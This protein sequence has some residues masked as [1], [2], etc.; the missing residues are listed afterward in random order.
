MFAS[1]TNGSGATN[2]TVD[3]QK[4]AIKRGHQKRVN[5]S[6]APKISK[7]SNQIYLKNTTGG[8]INHSFSIYLSIHRILIVFYICNYA[9]Y[10]SKVLS[11]VTV[12]LLPLC[13]HIVFPVI[14][15]GNF[16][17]Q[18]QTKTTKWNNERFYFLLIISPY[19]TNLN[20]AVFQ[21][22][23]SS[24]SEDSYFSHLCSPFPP[25]G[26][27]H[28]VWELHDPDD[29]PSDSFFR[30][31]EKIPPGTS[32]VDR[33]STV[34][35]HL[36]ELY[37]ASLIRK[38]SETRIRQL[39]GVWDLWQKCGWMT[40]CISKRLRGTIYIYICIALQYGY[41][42]VRRVKCLFSN[43]EMLEFS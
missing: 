29:I 26:I 32:P 31:L 20:L 5:S 34:E 4:R 25:I 10:I 1:G 3:H 11:P 38:P 9:T 36:V 6:F 24:N 12:C 16:Q 23:P 17:D 28:F 7:S 40:Q 35:G 39:V 13:H 27:D 22:L 14:L 19:F 43:V 42:M 37:Q 18:T 21:A 15:S 30:N 41:V 33:S 2:A 8:N